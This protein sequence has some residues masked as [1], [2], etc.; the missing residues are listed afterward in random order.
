MGELF[1]AAESQVE[2]SDLF[3][4]L[5]LGGAKGQLRRI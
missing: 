1:T 5:G 3:A 4:A 2:K